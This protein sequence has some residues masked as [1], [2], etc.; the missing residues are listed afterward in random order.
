MTGHWTLEARE[1]A[2]QRILK[3][4]PWIQSTGPQSEQGKA[5]AS[6]NSTSFINQIKKGWCIKE[7]W[8]S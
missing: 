8:D 5:I 4:K 1:A 7:V 2:R 6:M 3:N